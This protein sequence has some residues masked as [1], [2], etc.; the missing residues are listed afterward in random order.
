MK[1]KLHVE[2]SRY[3]AGTDMDV[4]VQ[5]PAEEFLDKPEM[6][7]SFWGFSKKGALKFD[8][9]SPHRD[10]HLRMYVTGNDEETKVHWFTKQRKG[11]FTVEKYEGNNDMHEWVRRCLQH[12]LK[13]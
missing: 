11:V 2:W 10:V 12:A 4:E 13:K 3:F 5:A 7:V 8:I 1:L 6:F 9:T